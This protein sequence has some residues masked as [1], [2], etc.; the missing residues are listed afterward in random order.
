MQSSSSH[1]A[2]QASPQSL[3]ENEKT[4]TFQEFRVIANAII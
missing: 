1:H 3:H 4:K 2:E